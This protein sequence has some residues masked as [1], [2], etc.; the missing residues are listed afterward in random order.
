MNRDESIDYIMDV[1]GA[2]VASNQFRA[3]MFLHDDDKG[4]YYDHELGREVECYSGKDGVITDEF[5]NVHTPDYH[6]TLNI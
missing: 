5:G 2:E 3:I 1:A 4:T 6:V